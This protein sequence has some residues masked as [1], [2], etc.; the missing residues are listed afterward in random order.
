M[1]PLCFRVRERVG[2]LWYMLTEAMWNLTYLFVCSWKGSFLY[3]NYG[4]WKEL[5]CEQSNGSHSEPDCLLPHEY[6]CDS[7]VNLPLSTW[8]K[9]TQSE[10]ENRRRSWTVCQGERSTYLLNKCDWVCAY[11]CMRAVCAVHLQLSSSTP[12]S[13]SLRGIFLVEYV[14]SGKWVDTLCVL[15]FGMCFFICLSCC[16]LKFLFILQHKS[17]VKKTLVFNC[18]FVKSWLVE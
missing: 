1:L 18:I 9:W 11:L 17:V 3:Q 6:P 2:R 13:S 12:F 15:W 8:R 5:P 10:R 16:G 14:G 7:S 4:C